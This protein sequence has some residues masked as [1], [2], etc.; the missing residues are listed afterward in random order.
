MPQLDS[1]RRAKKPKRLPTVLS[2]DEVRQVL[3]HLDGKHWIAANLLYGSGLRLLECLRLRV[4]DI[5]FNLAQIMVRGG[6]GNKDRCTILPASVIDPLQEHLEKLHT[7]HSRDL[8]KGLGRV[9]LPVA[10]DRKYPMPQKNYAGSSSFPPHAMS[11]MAKPGI[12]SDFIC[13]RRRCSVRSSLPPGNRISRNVRRR[14]PCATIYSTG[15][16]RVVSHQP[17]YPCEQAKM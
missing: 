13:M 17:I 1:V 2:P 8:K 16:C 9:Y 7:I 10:L 4:Q 14:I 12:G 3:S 15:L 6:K 11:P 5:D